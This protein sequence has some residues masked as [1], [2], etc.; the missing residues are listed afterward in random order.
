LQPAEV[1]NAADQQA[2]RQDGLARAF[3][4]RPT[5]VVARELLGKALVH[6]DAGVRRAGRIVETEAYVGPDDAASHAR[7]GPDKRG[8]LMWGQAGVA[9]VYLI[10]GVH[11][12]FNVVT[13]TVGYP[14]AVLIRAIE[15]LEHA[16]RGSG[17]G[18]V[19]SALRIDRASSGLDLTCSDLW[20]ADAP[21]VPD[22]EIR[23][24][25]RIG[26][27]Y[28]GEWAS[29]PW[30]LWIGTSPHHSRPR[31]TGTTFDPAMLGSTPGGNDASATEALVA[32]Y[33][34][35][36]RA[37]AARGAGAEPRAFARDVRDHAAGAHPR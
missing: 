27:D 8:A 1:H 35:A 28:A 14:G 33:P 11:N 16:G 26:V 31:I 2:G 23:V 3:Y 36:R 9:Y 30:R 12:C 7:S 10:Y 19:C 25:P 5:L 21:A 4:A 29:R 15:P 13:E 18:L 17:P 37:G 22:A 24:G 34:R 32:R 6:L 20:I